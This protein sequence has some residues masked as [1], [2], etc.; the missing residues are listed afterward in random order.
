VQCPLYIGYDLFLPER[1]TGKT[2]M[3]DG[4]CLCREEAGRREGK[5][6]PDSPLGLSPK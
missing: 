5:A 3:R 2:R 1:K 4:S 6:G